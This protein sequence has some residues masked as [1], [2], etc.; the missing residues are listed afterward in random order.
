MGQFSI[1]LIPVVSEGEDKRLLISTKYISYFEKFIYDEILNKKKIIINSK[2]NIWLSLMFVNRSSSG[3][4]FTCED[5]DIMPP[6][7]VGS[8]STRFYPIVIPR[9]LITK[10]TN[11][12]EVLPETFFKAIKLFFSNAYKKIDVAFIESLWSKLDHN[13]LRSIPYPAPVSDV[14]YVGDDGIVSNRLE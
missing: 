14:F 7:Y 11:P 3:E 5:I 13:Y 6:T 4:N 8:E 10:A 2:I 9:S 12:K 1:K